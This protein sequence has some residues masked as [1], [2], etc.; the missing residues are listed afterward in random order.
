MIGPVG[1]GLTA[2]DCCPAWCDRR[3]PHDVHI[4]HLGQAAGIFVQVVRADGAYAAR[5]REPQV[6]IRDV[7]GSSAGDQAELWLPPAEARQ[8]AVILARLGHR[9]V[10]GLVASA[11]EVSR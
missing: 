10:S 6:V 7:S 5:L 1:Y 4:R 9:E 8:L 2:A 3:E 11:A